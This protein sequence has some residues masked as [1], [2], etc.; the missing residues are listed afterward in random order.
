MKEK[1]TY[2]ELNEA[3]RYDPETGVIHWRN[4]APRHKDGTEAGFSA[5]GYKV[6][7]FKGKTYSYNQIVWVL[8]CEEWPDKV[9]GFKDG[10]PQNTRFENL[11]YGERPSARGERGPHPKL[12][13]GSSTGHKGV[14][15]Y[16]GR[17]KVTIRINGKQKSVGT[18]KTKE[19][20]IEAR[21]AAEEAF[22]N[23]DSVE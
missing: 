11:A 8:N 12:S 2:E 4:P 6:I 23:L 16:G 17:W 10:N 14:C 19:E 18:Y 22:T 5:H 20:A 15:Y 21:R 1:P 7:H 9:I 3:F 13:K